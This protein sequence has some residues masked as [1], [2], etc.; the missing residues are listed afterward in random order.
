MNNLKIYLSLILAISFPYQLINSNQAFSQIVPDNTLG[1]ESSIV[2]P[3]NI[4]NDRIDGGAIRGKNLFHSFSDFNIN[5]GKGVYFANPAT[6]ENILTR[7]TGGNISSILGRLGVLGEANLFFLN[8]NGILFGSNAT[9]DLKGSFTASTASHIVF[10]DNSFFSAINHSQSILSTSIPIGLG[11]TNP[12]G[13][14]QVFGKGHRVIQ[15]SNPKTPRQNLQPFEIGLSVQPGRTLSLSASKIEFTGGIITSLSGNLSIA[16][17]NSGELKINWYNSNLFSINY[18]S[19]NPNNITLTHL[20]LL[21]AKGTEHGNIQIFGKD[22]T[23]TDSSSILSENQG[24]NSHNSIQIQAAGTLEVIGITELSP[25]FQNLIRPGRG[26]S[27][28]TLSAGK[29]ADIVIQARDLILRSSAGV[30]TTQFGTG[31]AGDILVDV[32]GTVNIL[33]VA[34]NDP[35]FLVGSNIASASISN[36]KSGSIILNSKNLTIQQGGFLSTFV[37]GNGLG[38]D[39]FVNSNKI[40]VE[41]FNPSSFFPSLISVNNQDR[42][43]AGNLQISSEYI[44]VNNGGRIDASNLA[45]GRAGNL[46]ITA[47]T[48]EVK[49][50]SDI[51]KAPSLITASSSIPN[52]FLQQGLLLPESANGFSGNLIISANQIFVLDGASINVAHDGIGDGGTLRINSNSLKLDNGSIVATS[53]AGLG[54]NIFLNTSHDISLGGNSTIST[55]AGGTGN[56]GNIDINARFLILNDSSL[57]AAQAFQGRGGNI[58]LRVEGLLESPQSLI[59]A[60]SDLGIDGQIT[61]DRSYKFEDALLTPEYT[62]LQTEEILD[63]FCNPQDSK[64]SFQSVGSGSLPPTPDS[65]LTPDNIIT[66]PKPSSSSIQSEAPRPT[67]MAHPD[68]KWKG[69]RIVEGNTRL[70][71]PDGRVILIVVPESLRGSGD[72]TCPSQKPRQIIEK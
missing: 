60:S 27:S 69:G 28:Q 10:Q 26:I 2:N 62:Y 20:S 17:L 12:T 41:G 3:I 59:S 21:N 63:R 49:G 43:A 34:P 39:I 31:N 22:I 19:N 42:G 36:A 7:V 44:L 67:V 1:T 33:G 70:R 57:I 48:I 56:G 45:L 47:D 64:G 51:L 68:S 24:S 4:E 5:E 52:E 61:I 32:K 16:S 37:L 71:L 40:L 50:K 23:L 65:G 11:F 6:V 13:R 29:G 9:L 46:I 15:S 14:I 66:I 58:N 25:V 53:Q 38:G 54:G 35:N 18:Q 8:P 30:Y 55:T 72:L